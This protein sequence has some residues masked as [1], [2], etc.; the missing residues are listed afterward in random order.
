MSIALPNLDRVRGRRPGDDG[1]ARTTTLSADRPGGS[2]MQL[3]VVV[4]GAACMAPIAAALVL[5]LRLNGL[6]QFL[7][8]HAVWAGLLS[9]LILVFPLVFFIERLAERAD[10]RRR[11]DAAADQRKRWRRPAGHSLIRIAGAARKG[12]GDIASAG[13]GSPVRTAKTR[14]VRGEWIEKLVPGENGATWDAVSQAAWNAFEEMSNALINTTPVLALYPEMDVSDEMDELF[15]ALLEFMSSAD[16]VRIRLSGP[17]PDAGELVSKWE[18]YDQSVVRLD[19]AVTS[20]LA[21]NA[22]S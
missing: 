7:V 17:A 9:G 18:R 16:R 2:R 4:I 21:R 10:A 1:P 14:K 8:D 3:R 13:G 11:E 19:D 22:R 6:R 15:T 20:A 5:D 12:P